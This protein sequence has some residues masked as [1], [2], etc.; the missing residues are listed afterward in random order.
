MLLTFIAKVNHLSK[1]MREPL[2]ALV[3]HQVGD[4]AGYSAHGQRKLEDNKV[5][6]F[7]VPLGTTINMDGTAIMGSCHCFY[8]SILRY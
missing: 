4:D 2:V 3:P 7:A 5:A 6:S 1:K 8:C